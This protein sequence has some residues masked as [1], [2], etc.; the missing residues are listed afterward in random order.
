MNRY[1]L[2]AGL[3][4]AALCVLSALGLSGPASAGDPVPFKGTLQGS[5]T[6]TGTF[7][8]FHLEPSGTGNATQL[9]QFSFT[10]P[11][12]VNLLLLP[13]GGTGTFVFTAANGDTVSGTF[14][15][16]A[17]PTQVPGVIHGVE[18]MT[19]TGGT[20]RFANA[21]GSFT[22]DRLV[23]TV[24]LTTVGSFEGTISSPGR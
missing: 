16:S 23:D 15:T 6:R 9:G 18:Y 11:H 14:L 12:D 1:R 22:T 17:T 13:P 4:L 8:F 3:A 5:Y 10:L 7:P 21:S 19:I 24:N 2:L 20:G